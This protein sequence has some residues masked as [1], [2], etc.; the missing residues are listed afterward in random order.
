MITQDFNNANCNY[1]FWQTKLKHKIYTQYTKV[2]FQ[3]NT[4]KTTLKRPCSLVT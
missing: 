4:E 2:N 3:N 1:Y